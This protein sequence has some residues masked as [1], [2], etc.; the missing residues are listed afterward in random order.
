MPSHWI[1]VQDGPIYHVALELA[2][3]DMSTKFRHYILISKH[4]SL[5]AA[6]TEIE[7]RIEQ[8]RSRS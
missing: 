4:S 2:C 1:I 5:V 7:R 3:D 8:E 6:E